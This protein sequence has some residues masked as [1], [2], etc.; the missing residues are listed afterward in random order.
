MWFERML[1]EPAQGWQVEEG[2]VLPPSDPGVTEPESLFTGS[3][4]LM[5]PQ[6]IQQYMYILAVT[7]LPTFAIQHAPGSTIALGRLDISWRSSFGE[8][9]RL[10]TSVRLNMVYK[11]YTTSDSTLFPRCSL[12]VFHCLRCKHHPASPHLPFRH[13]SSAAHQPQPPMHQYQATPVLALGPALH[14]LAPVVL[15]HPIVPAHLS[16]TGQCLYLHAQGVP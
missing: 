13:T 15:Q 7:S 8:P 11:V 6:D 12:D 4:A 2:N 5:Q 16:R 10:L 9:G 14:P 3:Q 1:F